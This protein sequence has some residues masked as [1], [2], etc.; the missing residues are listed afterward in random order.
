[1]KMNKEKFIE[2][3]EK[4]TGFSKEKCEKVNEILEENFLIGKENKNK[5]VSQI[6]S[7]FGCNE[8]EANSLYET[9]A[10]IFFGE[11]KN[12]LLH[13]FKNQD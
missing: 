2:E 1:M 12:K 6:M 10:S 7:E 5:M 8:T 11:V 3:L 9:V 13:P 4:K